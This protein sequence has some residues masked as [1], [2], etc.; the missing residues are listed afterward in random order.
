MRTG[1]DAELGIRHVRHV[2][3]RVKIFSIPTRGEADC[4]HDTSWAGSGREVQGLWITSIH[5]L[6]TCESK[7]AEALG[8]F[9]G[10]GV[11][12][13]DKHAEALEID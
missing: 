5:V 7:L 3:R 11:D 10:A 8:F 1:C 12:V 2:V 9:F 13:S 4:G 6:Q